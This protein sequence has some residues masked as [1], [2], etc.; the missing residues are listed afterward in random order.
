MTCRKSA[1]PKVPV[2]SC[3]DEIRSVQNQDQPAHVFVNVAAQR[4]Q[5]RFF[6]H[7]CRYGTFLRAITAEVESFDRRI[8]K[9]V[10]IS[11]VEIRK[12]NSG[13]NSDRKK[14]WNERQILLRDLFRCRR[15]RARESTIEIN[16]G[17]RWLCR[18]YTPFG[19]DLVAFYLDRC[20]MRFREFYP[21]LDDS[22]RQ[23]RT[24]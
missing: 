17:Q 16:D 5:T 15:S 20:R 11:V 22:A 8:G 14:R 13:S 21:S 10:V 1:Q 9:D 23:K 4:N 3:H 7:L 2:R 18:K 19:D 6:E 12:F 24:G